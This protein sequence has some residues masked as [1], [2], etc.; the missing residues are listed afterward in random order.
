MQII[1]IIIMITA[2]RLP[3]LTIITRGLMEM[4]RDQEVIREQV[5]ITAIIILSRSIYLELIAPPV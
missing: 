3:I 1:I 4:I 5:W 2:L